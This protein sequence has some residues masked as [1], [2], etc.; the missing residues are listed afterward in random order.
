MN[1]NQP[2][3]P[4]MTRETDCAYCGASDNLRPHDIPQ[5]GTP[6]WRLASVCRDQKACTARQD[7]QAASMWPEER[8]AITPA[9]RAALEV[10]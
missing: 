4:I 3:Q 7:A 8:F 10:A 2:A 9:G 6:H 1:S 5:R